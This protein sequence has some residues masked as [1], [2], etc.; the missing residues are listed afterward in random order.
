MLRIPW[1]Y[2]R[3]GGL[4]NQSLVFYVL[5]IKIQLNVD[6]VANEI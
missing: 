5:V 6:T 2:W 3:S 1:N 4:L